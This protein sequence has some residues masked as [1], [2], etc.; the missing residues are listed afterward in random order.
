MHNSKNFGDME[1]NKKIGMKNNSVYEVC[2]QKESFGI[3]R[4]LHKSFLLLFKS[5]NF[6]LCANQSNFDLFS[7]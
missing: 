2:E 5:V 4:F 6:D 7:N 3:D 1:V